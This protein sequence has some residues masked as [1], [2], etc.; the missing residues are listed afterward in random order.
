[1]SGVIII[2]VLTSSM[3]KGC[4]FSGWFCTDLLYRRE[5]D[6]GEK[7]ERSQYAPGG[8]ISGCG[9]V[10]AMGILNIWVWNND[11]AHEN[12]WM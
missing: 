8:N 3:G 12:A 10:S 7:A 11:K 6:L 5:S 2:A 9:S 1:M 4:A